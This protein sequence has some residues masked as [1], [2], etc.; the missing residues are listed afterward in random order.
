MW[1]S[2]SRDAGRSWEQIT[3]G[4][5]IY[6]FGD[7]GALM[8]MADNREATNKVKP[9]LETRNMKHMLRPTDVANVGREIKERR[10]T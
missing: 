6:E 5:Y 1:Y 8:I 10:Y 3:E 7:H 2:C 4:S 9:K